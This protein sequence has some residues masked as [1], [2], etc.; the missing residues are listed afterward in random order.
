MSLKFAPVAS[1]NSYTPR[2][3]NSQETTNATR[4]T[5]AS[6]LCRTLPTT[7]TIS[8]W[9]EQER[10]MP[11]T[12]MIWTPKSPETHRFLLMIFGVQLLE[13]SSRRG[14]N[15]TIGISDWRR[16]RTKSLDV[17][18]MDSWVHDCQQEFFPGTRMN[19][20]PRPAHQLCFQYSEN[21]Y[22]ITDQLLHV[23]SNWNQRLDVSTWYS[24]EFLL[25]LVW[26]RIWWKL[27]L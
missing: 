7:S 1:F 12:P 2:G 17:V 16:F 8:P 24:D 26:P 14:K 10:G 4:G 9:Q 15:T 13:S 20:E 25:P 3:M 23:L 18:W 6:A 11:L 5:L 19:I 21:F 22:W 27:E